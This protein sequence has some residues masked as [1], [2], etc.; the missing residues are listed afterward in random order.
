MADGHEEH[1]VLG[2][3]GLHFAP[4]DAVPNG[5]AALGAAALHHFC[6]A[7]KGSRR[8]VVLIRTSLLFIF[9]LLVI[10]YC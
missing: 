4:N 1:A 3:V 9:G 6:Q 10:V 7:R 8:H 2:A 5:R